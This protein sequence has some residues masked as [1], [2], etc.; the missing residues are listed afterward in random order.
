VAS[1]TDP[2][3]A[4]TAAARQRSH[5]FRGKDTGWGAPRC[6]RERRPM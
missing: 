5:C 3:H 6:F 4:C 2:Q 1:I